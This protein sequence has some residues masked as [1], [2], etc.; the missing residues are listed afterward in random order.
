MF[1][2]FAGDNTTFQIGAVNRGKRQSLLTLVATPTARGGIWA[3]TQAGCSKK[4]FN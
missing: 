4:N 2:R 3:A 1:H